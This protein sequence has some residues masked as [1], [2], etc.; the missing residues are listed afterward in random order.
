[1]RHNVRA[2]LLA[3]G[4]GTRLR[5]LTDRW[6]K[7]LMPI[8]ERALLEY[9]LETLWQSGV[10]EVLVNLHYLPRIVHDFLD[11]PRFRN[12][13]H[14]VEEQQLL[15]TAGTIQANAEFFRDHTVLLLHADNYCQ[16]KFNDFLE[17]HRLHRPIG[18][19]MTMMTFDTEI[20]ETC[21]IV[22]TD[23]HGVVQAFHEKVEKPPGTLANAAVYLLEPEI[24]WW[25]EENPDL[26]D[27]ST[28]ILPQYIGRIATW[29]NDGNH[30]DIGTTKELQEAQK[31]PKPTSFWGNDMWQQR[32]L[33]HPIHQMLRD[34]YDT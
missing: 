30:R 24:L 32:F 13:V 12:W 25:I 19:L 9:W 5:P 20:P 10:Q 34:S 29:H 3:A 15:G 28:Q 18:T 17:F 31:D 16:C 23:A 4:M 27:F 21:G 33:R 6:P 7:C 26:T 2:L 14:S 1:M 22:E 8:G 11:R